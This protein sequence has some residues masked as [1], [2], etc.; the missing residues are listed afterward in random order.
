MKELV[1]IPWVFDK[2]IFKGVHKK[3]VLK[4]KIFEINDR[5]FIIDF[6]GYSHAFSI[7][8]E[9]KKKDSFS[10]IFFIGGAA[11][12]SEHKVGDIVIPEKSSIFLKYEDR[13][14]KKMILSKEELEFLTDN[15]TDKKGNLLTIDFAGYFPLYEVPVL[16]KEKFDL[17][18]MECG[19]IHLWSRRE[20]KSFYPLTII[21]DRWGDGKVKVD[22]SV[23]KAFRSLLEKFFRIRF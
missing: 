6:L 15:F 14:T 1:L 5:V 9:M 17:I 20:G 16:R 19:F 21:T 4:A 11:T 18:E 22:N 10:K 23:K 7:L 3:E 8:E 12:N 13:L 2:E